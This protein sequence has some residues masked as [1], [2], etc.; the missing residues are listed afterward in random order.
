MIKEIRKILFD[1]S[2]RPHSIQERK[3]KAERLKVIRTELQQFRR[4]NPNA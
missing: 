1:L 4:E 3:E 2:V